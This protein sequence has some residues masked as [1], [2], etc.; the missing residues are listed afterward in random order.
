LTPAFAWSAAAPEY[1]AMIAALRE[2][3]LA[4]ERIYYCSDC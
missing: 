1:L 4:G 2:R 3:V